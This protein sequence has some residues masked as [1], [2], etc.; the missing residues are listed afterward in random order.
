MIL[1]GVL[2]LCLALAV[3][4]VVTLYKA[5][6]HEARAEASHPPLGQFIGIDGQRIHAMVHGTGP[7]LVLIHGSSGNLR[8]FPKALV[9]RLATHFRVILLDRPGLGYS[10]DIGQN[11][12][13]ISE[14][15][16]VLRRAARTLGADKPI[17]LGHS[18]GGAVAL[19]WATSHPEALAALVL[20]SS[21]SNLWTT[22]LDPL[23]QLTSHPILG[24]LAIPVLTAFV[25]DARI[26]AAIASVFEPQAPPVGYTSFIG[27]GLT[28]RRT[29]MRANAQQR[30]NLQAEIAALISNYRH[31]SAA[32]EI[33]HGTADTIVSTK[34]HSDL[35]VNQI[36]N[37]RLTLLDGIGHMPHH[38]AQDA[39]FDA[40]MR[41]AAR[42]RL[43]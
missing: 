31:I 43:H 13:T 8:D 32:T 42:T 14:Q 41:A 39:V 37:A 22:P 17:V 36:K 10:D 12:A 5:R 23:Y 18:Y 28:L 9:E 38:V 34:I 16:D 20:L 30:A 1:K 3:F 2:F 25:A 15:A 4:I 19:A 27:S 7:D 33:L 24:P 11:G 26:E 21:P 40:I 35:L 29:T 6:A